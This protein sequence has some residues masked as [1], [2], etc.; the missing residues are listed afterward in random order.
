MNNTNVCAFNMVKILSNVG[1][2]VLA[3]NAI[4]N[5]EPGSNDALLHATTDLSTW[6]VERL[7]RGHKQKQGTSTPEL[8]TEEYTGTI[9]RVNVNN[10]IKLLKDTFKNCNV[11]LGSPK[12]YTRYG[13]L[14][15]DQLSPQDINNA[16]IKVEIDTYFGYLIV[17]NENNTPFSNQYN[18]MKPPT[19][20]E[21]LK[22]FA[23]LFTQ[24]QALN[25]TKDNKSQVIGNF[26]V[27][28]DGQDD[29]KKYLF[30]FNIIVKDETVKLCTLSVGETA[31]ELGDEETATDNTA[32]V[33][34]KK[35]NSGLSFICN[36]IKWVISIA[37]SSSNDNYEFN[38]NI[39]NNSNYTGKIE[40]LKSIVKTSL[41]NNEELY[42][43]IKYID[44][45][46]IKLTNSENNEVYELNVKGI[47]S[48]LFEFVIKQNQGPE[49]PICT[50]DSINLQQEF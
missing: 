50:V 33:F 7:R 5:N 6:A 14:Y 22:I 30:T 23:Q 3:L 20:A 47:D 38:V 34:I 17:T 36:E 31:P 42:I 24:E 2:I 32:E 39:V 18:T 41:E 37:D 27:K 35:I 44:E 49:K 15:K 21:Q 19:T 13:Y 8:G 10:F 1:S 11:K 29:G 46:G 12:F 43:F 25:L 28:Y 45:S 16:S 26:D 48:T 4:R 9:F 40:L